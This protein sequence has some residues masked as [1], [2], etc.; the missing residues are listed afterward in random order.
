MIKW[1]PVAGFHEGC[2]CQ[3]SAQG[4]VSCW[5]REALRPDMSHPETSRGGN[6]ME[7]PRLGEFSGW[8]KHSTF[9]MSGIEATCHVATEH[10][11][12][13]SC[14]WGTEFL[15]LRTW[16]WFKKK[17]CLGLHLQHMKV[18]KPG[19]YATT[20]AIPDVRCICGL[21]HS[22]WQHRILNPLSEAENW[23]CILMDTGQIRFHR[24]TME[25]LPLTCFYCINT[26]SCCLFSLFIT[27][28]KIFYL[29]F[30]RSIV[31]L[32]CFRYTAQWFSYTY[33]SIY[34]YSFLDSFPL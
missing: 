22:L 27:T 12:W 10:L 21:H 25:W 2:G 31:Y 11:K 7:L 23:T 1:L 29:F 30:N 3:N 13:D 34:S 18:P 16:F 28:I 6:C 26:F 4:K 14:K 24:V 8:W 32:L 17:F 9:L 19:V 20:T 5:E 15:I 33:T